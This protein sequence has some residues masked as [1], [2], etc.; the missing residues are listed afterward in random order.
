MTTI[1]EYIDIFLDLTVLTSAVFVLRAAARLNFDVSTVTK[2]ATETNQALIQTS[3]KFAEESIKAMTV[4]IDLYKEHISKIDTLIVPLITQQYE[5]I[6]EQRTIM[7]KQDLILEKQ[8][9][10]MK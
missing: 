10:F 5:L 8:L 6:D 4:A 7:E 9:E 1:F 2:K 3:T